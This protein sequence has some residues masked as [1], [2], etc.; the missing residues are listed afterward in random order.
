MV[1]L[2]DKI[3]P[4][5]PK[6]TEDATLRFKALLYQVSQDKTS[7]FSLRKAL[8][9]QFL[10]TNI[11]IALTENGIVSSRGFVQELMGKIKHKLLPELQAPDNFLYVV[12]KIF[13]K[14]NGSYMGGGD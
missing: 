4:A 14:K 10:R 2:I 9:T 7:L 1:E 5:N 3:R 13:Y 8:L 6:N 11:V 12:N